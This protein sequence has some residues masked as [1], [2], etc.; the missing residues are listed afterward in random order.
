MSV[1][2]KIW[3]GLK[4]SCSFVCSSLTHKV[5]FTN[6]KPVAA[7]IEL[8]NHCNLRCAECANGSQS[9]TREKGFMEYA[10]FDRFLTE[11]E[12]FMSFMSLYFQGEP[13]LHPDFFSFVKRAENI[14]T[15]VSTNGHFLSVENAE[16]T[17][18]SSLNNIIISLDGMNEET[19]I[20]YRRGGDFNKVITGIKN[21]SAARTKYASRINIIV[22][23]LVNRQNEQQIPEIKAFAKKMDIT[24]KLKSMQII[25][26]SSFEQWVPDEDRYSRY[27]KTGNRYA[28]KSSLPNRCFR[29]WFN[30]VI[31]WDGYVLPCCYDKN[32]AY[33]MGNLYEE[34]FS[35]IWNNDRYRNFRQH[36]LTRRKDIDICRN[37][38]SGLKNARSLTR[39]GNRSR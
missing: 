28:I 2:A 29:L 26:E 30:P 17:V 33:K 10:L 19:Y 4:A 15:T 14:C 12:P 25:N 23:F 18:K 3:N 38:T 8:T 6:Y 11:T 35:D 1:P 27:R 24:L 16:K 34:T 21:L 36:V 7:G 32:A 9:M 39:T 13:M 31:T 20:K 22:Q 5:C 37:C